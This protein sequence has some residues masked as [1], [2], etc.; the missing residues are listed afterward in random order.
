MP[1][2][3]V[4][5][6]WCQCCGCFFLDCRREFHIF[7]FLFPYSK[8]NPNTRLECDARVACYAETSSVWVSKVI[9][10]VPQAVS[11]IPYEK[12]CANDFHPG[13]LFRTPWLGK[14]MS[15]LPCP[16]H[17]HFYGRH[18]R[19]PRNPRRREGGRNVYWVFACHLPCLATYEMWI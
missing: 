5:P 4:T 7:P 18:P 3:Q 8:R 14:R 6:A 19:N 13:S 11:I 2:T 10:R 12:S 9:S 1:F 16:S 15:C 17:H